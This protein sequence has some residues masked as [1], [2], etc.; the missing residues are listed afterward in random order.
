M[1]IPKVGTSFATTVVGFACGSKIFASTERGI[2]VSSDCDINRTIHVLSRENRNLKGWFEK[3]VQ[4]KHGKPLHRVV[5]LFRDPHDRRR[6]EFFYLTKKLSL[7]K[8]NINCCGFITNS[9]KTNMVP[10]LSKNVSTE[11]RLHNYLEFVRPYQGCMTNMIMGRRCF[12]GTP[13]P[14]MVSRAIS[15]VTNEMEFVGLQEKWNASVKLWHARFGGVIFDNEL[16]Q[17]RTNTDSSIQNDILYEDVDIHV[18]R[19]AVKRF[20]KDFTIVTRL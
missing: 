10:I 1:K 14:K 20:E 3:P 7:T 6:S 11:Q 19:A 2:K 9:I 4:W 16:T 13:S 12:Y 15:F 5:A 18:Y 17:K 8:N